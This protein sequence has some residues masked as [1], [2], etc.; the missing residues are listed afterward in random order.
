MYRKIEDTQQNIFKYLSA[1]ISQSRMIDDK[2]A[3]LYGI[4]RELENK[5]RM[6]KKKLEDIKKGYNTTKV[7]D[8]ERDVNVSISRTSIRLDFYKYFYEFI[9]MLI[10][11]VLDKERNEN[12]KATI[13]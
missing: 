9:E 5:D 3:K 10:L 6:L 7:P 11:L 1:T 4:V 12:E 13:S 2:I 8:I